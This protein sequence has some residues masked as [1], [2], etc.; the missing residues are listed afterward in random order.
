MRPFA[1]LWV[2]FCGIG[3]GTSVLAQ[4]SA[5]TNAPRSCKDYKEGL[6][7]Q[8]PMFQ[9]TGRITM[10]TGVVYE[11]TQFGR[12]GIYHPYVIGMRDSLRGCRFPFYQ[13]SRIEF[14]A[15]AKQ[16]R[17]T[18]LNGQ[19]PDNAG[20]L[21]YAA[22][23]LDHALVASPVDKAKVSWLN[24]IAKAPQLAQ[25]KEMALDPRD[26][27]SIEM[28]G[29]VAPAAT[30]S[31]TVVS[32]TGAPK[33]VAGP[34]LKFALPTTIESFPPPQAA[35]SGM[36]LLFKTEVDGSFVLTHLLEVAEVAKKGRVRV[37]PGKQ[38]LVWVSD[39]GTQAAPLWAETVAFERDNSR[40]KGDGRFGCIKS[41][42][43]WEAETGGKRSEP[44]PLTQYH[45]C[46]S[47]LTLSDNSG[48]ATTANAVTTVLTLGLGAVVAQHEQKRIDREKLL[49][50]LEKATPEIEAKLEQLA[51]RR[52]REDFAAAR[53]IDQID[54]YIAR[55]ESF[56]S[57]GLV[58]QMRQRRDG[59]ENARSA[60]SAGLAE[61]RAGIKLETDTNCGPT[62]EVRGNLVKVYHPVSGFGNEHWIKRDELLP[63]GMECAFKD[64][65]YVAPKG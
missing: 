40:F 6:P 57:E 61:F 43:R 20:G 29:P 27:A 25:P 2:I 38:E 22:G 46:A 41:F 7:T 23:E 52:Y 64:G 55:Y 34:R 9:L 59:A 33:P 56:D 60:A 47:A 5:T 26:I 36:L 62:L 15:Y 63:K 14:D 42:G 35:R 50:V 13:V 12:P 3:I 45:P 1:G 65:H 4:G 37:A 39:D 16:W 32:G 18:L 10:K 44:R 48:T 31:A 51:A 30:A 17:L 8:D 49:S 53:T 54:A 21:F 28:L 19:A 24:V 11:V 58:A